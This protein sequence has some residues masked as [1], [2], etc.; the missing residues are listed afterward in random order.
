MSNAFEEPRLAQIYDLLYPD[1]SDLDMYVALVSG[2]DRSWT[3]A[4]APVPSA[5]AARLPSR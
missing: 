4:A 1:R 2:H 3:W 5:N